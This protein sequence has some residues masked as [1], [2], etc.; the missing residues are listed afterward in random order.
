MQVSLQALRAFEAAARLSSF[1]QAAEE[2]SLTPTTVS[3]HIANL[4]S[5]LGV[6]LFHRQNRCIVLTSTGQFL[7]TAMTEGFTIINNALD[8]VADTARVVRVT[9]TSSLA[10]ML[11]IPYQCEFSVIYPEIGV[12]ISTG[13]TLNNQ[14]YVI[15]IRLGD[16]A[17]VPPED[18]IK[19]EYFDVFGANQVSDAWY[20][21][22]K[23]TIYTTE[24]KNSKLPSPSLDT[25][26]A[27]ND[28]SRD[29]V[30]V[31]KFDQEFFAIQQ[32]MAEGCLVFCSSTMVTRLLKAGLLKYFQTQ[33]IKTQL[34]YYI[35]KKAS[36]D[37]KNGKKYLEWVETLLC[38]SS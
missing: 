20:S 16:V 24:W 26:L 6:S 18:I 25:W 36:F 15:P 8:Q 13:E 5:R 11:L 14:P 4:E 19:Q 37:S 17:R 34:C 7:A 28:I 2:L 9:T 10:A 38:S 1:K 29:R 33:T 30:L 3:H 12:E 21:Q 31:K 23:T 32:A 22:G 35:P 27:L